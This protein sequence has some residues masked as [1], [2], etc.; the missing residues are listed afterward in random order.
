MGIVRETRCVVV[1]PLPKSGFIAFI[2][3]FSW[4]YQTYI[5]I[6]ACKMVLNVS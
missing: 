4:I 6:F 2:S 5:N 1:R 3:I